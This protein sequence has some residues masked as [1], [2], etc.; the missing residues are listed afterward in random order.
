MASE[1]GQYRLVMGGGNTTYY[2][3][4][5]YNNW[6]Y[7]GVLFPNNDIDMY[8]VALST[9]SFFST[10]TISAYDHYSSEIEFT[11]CYP[12]TTYIKL[13]DDGTLDCLS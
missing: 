10:V 12:S 6:M 8:E 7:L 2:D 11:T 4:S 3:V 5:D 1:N 13:E 9:N